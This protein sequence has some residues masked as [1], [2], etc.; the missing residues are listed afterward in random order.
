MFIQVFGVIFDMFG[1]SWFF[2]PPRFET[3]KNGHKNRASVACQTPSKNILPRKHRE[4][5][6]YQ[7]AQNCFSHR[8]GHWFCPFWILVKLIR[9]NTIKTWDKKY[10]KYF[11][12]LLGK[13]LLS[14]ERAIAVLF[15]PLQHTIVRENMLATAAEHHQDTHH[16]SLL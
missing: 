16:I 5:K 8:I 7:K 1:E 11:K 10:S 9:R 4:R 15:K 6:I 13:F 2:M 3:T 14:A 12:E